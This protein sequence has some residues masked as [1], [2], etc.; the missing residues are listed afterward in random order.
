[1]AQKTLP[2]GQECYAGWSYFV[3]LSPLWGLKKAAVF[4]TWRLFSFPAGS[5]FYV[6]VPEKRRKTGQDG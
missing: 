6:H 2:E 4:I 5:L 1:M 3:F